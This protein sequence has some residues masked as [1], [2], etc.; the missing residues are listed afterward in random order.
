MRSFALAVVVVLAGCNGFAGDPTATERL[1]PVDDIRTGESYPPGVD[2]SGAVGPDALASSHTAIAEEQSYVL[3][4]NRTVRYE[5]GTLRSQLQV[6]VELASNR[7]FHVTTSTA[8]HA[9]PEFLGRPPATAEYWADGEVYLRYL[10]RDNE[11]V[12]N[13][14]Q[15]PDRFVGTWEFWTRTVAFG[16]RA[17]SSERT[18]RNVFGA[19]PTRI[20]GT[21]TRNGTTIYLLAGNRAT[22]LAFAPQEVQSADAVRLEAAVGAD[23]FVR[24]I[25]LQ[26][27]AVIAGERVTVDR[28]IS[29][30]NVGST[31]VSRPA[32]FDRA[33]G[34]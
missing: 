12:Y 19:I 2:E 30:L 8:G 5:N 21:E 1:T 4:S 6:R 13:T 18:I 16:G 25:T 27:D 32:W 9:G 7:T 31:A 26:Y 29:Y 15:P 33:M 14:F 28:R 34:N 17:G 10:Q 3:L 20:T 23:G 24:E 22:S 11:S